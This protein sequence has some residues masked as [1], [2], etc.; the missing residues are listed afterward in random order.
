MVQINRALAFKGLQILSYVVRDMRK[1]VA[2]RYC[3]RTIVVVTNRAP[4]L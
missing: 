2:Q 3:G 1:R 4:L